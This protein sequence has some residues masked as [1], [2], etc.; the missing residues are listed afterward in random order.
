MSIVFI[1]S[2]TKLDE[3]DIPIFYPVT[4]KTQIAA[5]PK[6]FNDIVASEKSAL[7]EQKVTLHRF[8]IRDS[9]LLFILILSFL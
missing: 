3:G 9:W 7:F 1:V 2:L 4:D 8:I 5:L 6:N